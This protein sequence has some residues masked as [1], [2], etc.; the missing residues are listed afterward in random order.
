MEPWLIVLLIVAS[1]A[2]L[3]LILSYLTYFIAFF[4]LR[5]MKEEL[6]LKKVMESF[7]PFAEIANPLLD[8][9]ASRGYETV[10]IKSFDGLSLV[11]KLYRGNE[12]M[13]LHIMFHGY[14]S[15]SRLDMA[16]GA[17]ECIKMGHSVL[18]VDQRAHGDS[19]GK[20]ISFGIK[21]KRDLADWVKFANE[22]I[23]SEKTPIFLWG[24]SMGAATVLMSLDL[25]F[26]ENVVGAIA[27]CPYSSPEAIIKKVGKALHVPILLAFPFLR[28]GARLFGGFRLGKT[29]A[30]DSVKSSRIPILLIHG[31][32]DGYVPHSMSVEIF[33]AA[34]SAGVDIR[35]ES[36]PEA[37][38]AKSYLVDTERYV[39]IVREFLESRA[40]IFA[41]GKK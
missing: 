23:V 11:G 9:L 17:E 40:A 37:E 15:L 32:A 36:F 19:E 2:A 16:G 28:L 18:L 31:E 4:S 38:H 21:E 27:D 6:Y 24:V 41:E 25:P 29:R 5:G 35:F 22:N 34:A 1:C 13:P 7:A 33:E 10:G 12:N 39:R 26:P 3:T 20:T 30:V 14:R 8:S